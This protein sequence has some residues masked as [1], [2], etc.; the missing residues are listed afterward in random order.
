MI[1]VRIMGG[2]G[3]QFFQYAFA[4]KVSLNLNTDLYFDLDYDRT[5]EDSLYGVKYVLDKY[6]IK[7]ELASKEI[8]DEIKGIRKQH[9]L[10]KKLTQKNGISGKGMRFLLSNFFSR[11]YYL[12]QSHIID[13]ANIPNKVLKGIKDNSYLDGYWARPSFFDDIL[14]ILRNELSIKKDFLNKKYY[15]YLNEIEKSNNSVSAHIR[16]GTYESIPVNKKF[17]GLMPIEYYNKAIEKIENTIGSNFTIFIFS[18][19][20]KWAKKNI[21]FKQKLVFVDVGKDYL[22]NQLMSTCSHNIIAN[23]TFSWWAAYL[24]D[25][26]NKIVIAPKQWFASEKRQKRYEKSDMIPDNWIKI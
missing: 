22:E 12:R 13:N 14:P 25:N 4:K 20:L 10:I 24:N 16:R 3:N 1:I 15:Y 7:A 6:N 21:K 5:I 9:N 11:A 26:P 17:F 2:P 23:S 8:I 18:N 19:D